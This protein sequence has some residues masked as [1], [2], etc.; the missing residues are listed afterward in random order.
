M[1]DFDLGITAGRSSIDGGNDTVKVKPHIRPLLVSKHN[2][3]N[4]TAG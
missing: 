1:G 2:D 3:C 4:L